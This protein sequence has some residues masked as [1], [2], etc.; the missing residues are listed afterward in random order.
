[1]RTHTH[2]HTNRLAQWGHQGNLS[3][4]PPPHQGFLRTV[5]AQCWK[6][7]EAGCSSTLSPARG[8]NTALKESTP[9]PMAM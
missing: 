2:T 9:M 1:M 8:K 4:R 7:L 3:S 6:C 5:P